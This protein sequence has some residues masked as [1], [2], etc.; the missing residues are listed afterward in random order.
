METSKMWN[1]NKWEK[2]GIDLAKGED[3]QIYSITQSIICE[4]VKEQ[5][6]HVM[7]LIES[8]VRKKQSE[9][10]IISSQIIGE[11]QLRHIINLGLTI[12]C[13]QKAIPI[14]EDDLFT[15]ED[16][17]EYL[18]HRLD[19]AEK[20]IRELSENQKGGQEDE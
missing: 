4:I 20:K 3:Q 1:K 14:S 11:G 5:D 12:Y 9:G 8:Y 2:H 19:M 13:K 10:E 6:E 7:A 17:I 15:Q 18:N 16:Y